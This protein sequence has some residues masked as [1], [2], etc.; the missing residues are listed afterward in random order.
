MV[1]KTISISDEHLEWLDMHSISLSK[2]IKKQIGNEIARHEEYYNPV[3]TLGK[4]PFLVHIET[5][6]PHITKKKL[7]ALYCIR[8]GISESTAYSHLQEYMD[9]GIVVQYGDHLLMYE[10]YTKESQT[11]GEQLRELVCDSC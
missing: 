1:T 3:H 9:A 4:E 6:G 11:N 2:F 8:E 5:N 10:Q 7:I